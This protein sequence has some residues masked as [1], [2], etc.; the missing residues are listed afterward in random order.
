MPIVR[1]GPLLVYFA[2]VPK[3]GGSAI[4]AYLAERFGRIALLDTRHHAN[5]A[6]KRWSRTSPQHMS[7]EVCQRLFPDG[8][9]DH[10]FAVVRHPVSRLISAY[11]F[12]KE[13]EQLPSARAG[14]SQWLDVLPEMM[15]EDPFVFDNHTRP[16][17]ELVPEGA[18]IFY[19]EHGLDA[20]VPWFDAITGRKDAPRALRPANERKGRK[21]DGVKVAPSADDL[22]VIERLYA[23]DFAR[24]GYTPG[25]KAPHAQP[26]ELSPDFIVERDAELARAARPGA[27]LREKLTRAMR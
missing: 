19:L 15:D 3:C 13:I 14:F 24:F 6:D 27:W 2:H 8:F 23:A 9:F 17:V 26:P 12:Q 22:A 21:S 1:A 5:P 11:H 25:Q 16:M 10:S 4:E 7:L 20:L 18:K